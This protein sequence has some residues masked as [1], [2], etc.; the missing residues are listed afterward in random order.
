MKIF[1]VSVLL[2]S[3][4]WGVTVPNFKVT[5]LNHK[6]VSLY[7]LT[8]ENDVTLFSLVTLSCPYC[9]KEIHDYVGLSQKFGIR[10]VGFVALFLESNTKKIQD[11]IREEKIAYPVLRAGE[12]MSKYFMLRGVPFTFIVDRKNNIIEKIPGY[13]P[14]ESLDEFIGQQLTR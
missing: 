4:V 6:V 11:L 8:Q 10:K 7:Q 13:V 3:L 14:A 9:L 5:D 2:S 12:D 1:I